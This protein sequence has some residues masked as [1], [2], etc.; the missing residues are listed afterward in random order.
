MWQR[1]GGRTGC[2]QR[3]K[4]SPGW[5]GESCQFAGQPW[6]RGCHQ[7]CA[8]HCRLQL[9]LATV[10]QSLCPPGL[11][12]STRRLRLLQWFL[13][14]GTCSQSPA[15]QHSP[16]PYSWERG[17]P[18]P[19]LPLLPALVLASGFVAPGPMP[20]PF[21]GLSAAPRARVGDW[22]A[23][24]LRRGHPGAMHTSCVCSGPCCSCSAHPAPDLALYPTASLP[25]CPQTPHTSHLTP[26]CLALPS[27][28]SSA[29]PGWR[30]DAGCP[31]QGDRNSG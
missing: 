4:G 8:L 6:P 23:P 17:L 29:L 10:W 5:E 7:P 3:G 24:P 13:Q 20:V 22:Q 30:H 19:H 15:S 28:P 18:A 27:V 1:V 25:T 2:R 16:S 14:R 26:R 21:L 12:T 9:P 31:E 11:H